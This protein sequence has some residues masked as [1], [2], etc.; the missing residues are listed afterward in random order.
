MESTIS[1]ATMGKIIW[2]PPQFTKLSKDTHITSHV[3]KIW[4]NLHKREKW[5]YNSP[6]IPL[7]DT[8]YFL[9][10]IEALFRKWIL[11][12]DAQLKNVMEQGK[13]CTY[14]KLKIKGEL[15]VIDFWQYSQL[16]HFIETPPQ[17]ISSV[18]NLRP[19]EK[20]CVDTTGG[21]GISRIYRVLVEMK[22]SEIPPFI[23]KWE[24]EL[25]IQLKKPDFRQLLRRVHATSVN[26]N[27]LELN[28]KCLARWYITPHRAHKYQSETLQFCW[29]GCKEIGTMAHI[30]WHC[31]DIKKYWGEIRQITSEITWRS[32]TTRGDAYSMGLGCL[33]GIT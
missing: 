1:K 17:P 5:E 23:K 11:Q 10:G 31:P 24:M 6:L 28:Y 14:Q 18:K 33:L 27:M 26:C 8:E 9:P 3:L 21:R 29:R 32:Q 2:I 4:D 30:W 7:K 15:M 19:L 16:N 12:K 20:L 13:T 25:G 22:G